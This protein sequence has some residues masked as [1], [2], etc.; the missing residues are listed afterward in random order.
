MSQID[1]DLLASQQTYLIL[2]GY[3]NFDLHLN[4]YGYSDYFPLLQRGIEGDILIRP[5][6]IANL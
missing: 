3:I 5:G 2:T 4:R 6:F 1:L